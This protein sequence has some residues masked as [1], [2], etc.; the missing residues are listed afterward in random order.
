MSA[1]TKRHRAPNKGRVPRSWLEDKLFARPKR[2]HRWHRL[3]RW[4][5]A[6]PYGIEARAC[7]R[8]NCRCMHWCCYQQRRSRRRA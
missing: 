2:E 8:E 7:T 5:P 6:P 4:S 1:R 3:D